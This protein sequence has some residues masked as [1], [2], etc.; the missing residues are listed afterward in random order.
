MQ[1]V[2]NYMVYLEYWAYNPQERVED[3][4]CSYDSLVGRKVLCES[5]ATAT[6]ENTRIIENLVKQNKGAVEEIL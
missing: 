3:F 2:L 5:Y 6:K 4:D 1:W